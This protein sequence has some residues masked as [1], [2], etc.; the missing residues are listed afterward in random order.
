MSKLTKL[1]ELQQETAD[2]KIRFTYHALPARIKGLY[3]GAYDGTPPA[4]ALNTSIRT[5]IEK[6]CVLAEE[7]GHYHTSSG[8]LLAQGSD[9]LYVT[10][11]E[12]RASRWA[13]KKLIP[14]NS[15]I[16]AFEY[17]VQNKYELADYLGVTEDF[18]DYSTDYYKKIYGLLVSVNETYT[19]YFEPFGIFKDLE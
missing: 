17:G 11:Q 1:E 9:K 5:E 10:K 19:I 12:E 4:I 14:L 3:Y 15:F 7:L 8:N 16:L 2:Q 6:T 13:T 18:L